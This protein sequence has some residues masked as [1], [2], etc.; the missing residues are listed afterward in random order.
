MVAGAKPGAAGASNGNGAAAAKVEATWLSTLPEDLRGNP[1]L[2]RYKG[3]EPFVR[4]HL[5][6]ES[7]LGK[8]LT[9]PGPEASEEERSAFWNKL[10]RPETAD[11]YE[12]NIPAESQVDKQ[13]LDVARA[14]FHEIGL[15]NQQ[16][17]ALSE[18]VVN[19]EA[20][21]N[22]VAAHQ[23]AAG[24]S[25]LKQEW[26]HSYDTNV[27]IASRALSQF[28]DGE[29]AI[30]GLWE[31]MDDPKIGSNPAMIRLF[32]WLG[33][34]MGEDE[35]II[36]RETP[37]EDTVKEIDAEIARVRADAKLTPKQRSQKLMA[38]Y[39]QKN[40]DG[41]SVAKRG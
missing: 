29:N 32:A 6:L 12:L 19:Q 38:L 30:P 34:A 33:K 27:A 41:V 26:G 31:L 37:G 7:K 22:Q 3:L 24:I 9:M 20:A 23:I 25:E 28:K 21:A 2:T 36:G 5:G 16:A 13:F 15:T 10:G 18:L 40:P 39:D 4:S 17:S 14:K 11:K 35:A 1:A 8:S